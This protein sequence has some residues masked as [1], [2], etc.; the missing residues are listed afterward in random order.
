MPIDKRQSKDDIIAELISSY[1]K[2]GKIGN[3]KPRD[4][5]HAQDIASGIAY[6][7][8][9]ESYI[10]NIKRYLNTISESSIDFPR[11]TLSQDVWEQT[12]DGYK[13]RKDVKDKI[14]KA[15]SSFPELDL[16]NIAKEVK[17]IGSIGSN[18][19]NDETDIDIH[20]IP[21]I[22]LLQGVNLEELQHDIFSYYKENRDTNNWYAGKH[23]FEVYLQLDS[24]Q[25]LMSIAVYDIITDN[26]IKKPEFKKLDYNPYEVFKDVYN[27][28]KNLTK[29]TDIKI[30]ELRRD[31]ID[32]KTIMSAFREL[33]D[34]YRTNLKNYLRDKIK[35]LEEGILSLAK[36]RESWR[37]MRREFS[38]TPEEFKSIED[39]RLSD[40]WQDANASFKFL[41]RYLYLK[42]TSDLGK[43]MDDGI[44]DDEELKEIDNILKEF[45]SKI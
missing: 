29:D 6:S 31:Y 9:S 42:L 37:E 41:D 24:L 13:L 23:P 1:K 8:K 19:Y 18:L 22:K 12:D 34:Y 40:K 20:V 7:I 2:T 44:L 28:I 25:D 21:N 15:L 45:N 17:I 39:L 11:Q 3:T 26:W 4:I 10:N 36:D 33:P 43:L 30:A 14:I 27:N 35:E 5:K 16:L 38:K 32:Y